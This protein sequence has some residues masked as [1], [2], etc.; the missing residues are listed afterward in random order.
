VE[1]EGLNNNLS[2]GPSP[3]ERG[4][5]AHTVMSRNTFRLPSPRERGRG[6]G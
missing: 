1:E 2:P 5:Q 4:D 6:R 3:E